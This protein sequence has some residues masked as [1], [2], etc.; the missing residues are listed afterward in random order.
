MK[1]GGYSVLVLLV[2]IAVLCK[3][4]Y[5]CKGP[6]CTA[7]GSGLHCTLLLT[8]ALNTASN[9]GWHSGRNALSFDF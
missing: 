6:A 5:I 2:R 9:I 1:C 7:V 4:A 8:S 3:A